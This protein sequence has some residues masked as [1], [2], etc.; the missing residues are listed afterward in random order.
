MRH[1]CPMC[2][3]P[4]MLHVQAQSL[5]YQGFVQPLIVTEC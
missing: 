1:L 5:R 2:S 4:I 3:D